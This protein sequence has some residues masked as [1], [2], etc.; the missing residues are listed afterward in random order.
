[1]KII[2]NKSLSLSLISILIGI[3]I[4]FTLVSQEK[5]TYSDQYWLQYYGQL[6][7]NTKWSVPFDA[8]IRMRKAISEKAATLARIAI[9][10]QINKVLS[11]A[12]G[13]AYFSQYNN[14]KIVREEWRGYQEILMKQNFNRCYTSH[15]LRLEERYYYSL[16]TKTD[17]FNFRLRYRFYLTIPLNHTNMSAKTLYIIAGDELFLNFGNTVIYNYDQNRAIA[18]FGYKPTDNLLINLT[19]VY[20]YTQKNS[21]DSFE[22]S[23]LLW[24]GIAQ[25][26]CFR[27]KDKTEN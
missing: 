15:R 18:G 8:G 17:F 4:S 20:Q 14:D 23:D 2:S 9:Q 3:S 12:L 19:Y 5:K 7:L 10:Y 25:T 1:V 26:L 21:T 13:G 16:P 24:L 11:T 27:K 6:Q 22:H